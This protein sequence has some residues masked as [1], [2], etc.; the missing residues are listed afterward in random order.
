MNGVLRRFVLAAALAGLAPGAG[1]QA[2]AAAS[3]QD[4]ADRHLYVGQYDLAT[5]AWGRRGAGAQWRIDLATQAGPGMDGA[6]YTWSGFA[7]DFSSVKAYASVRYGASNAR[8]DPAV[9]RLPYRFGAN[10]T[11]VD[12]VWDFT[13]DGVVGKFN[14]TLDIFFN[15]AGRS[16]QG[17]IR[18]EIMIVTASSQDARTAGWG[19]RDALP[20]VIGPETWYVWQATQVSNGHSWHVTQFRKRVG[21]Q[22]FHHNLKDFFAAAAARRP[23]IFS[24]DRDVMMV[25]AGTEIKTG[26]GQ[27]RLDRYRVTV[28]PAP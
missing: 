26:A 4:G 22:A 10:G 23:D 11:D 15:A 19:V 12:V 28:T 3:A 16:G 7:G 8:N 24:A 9:T 20:F 5:N 27:V 14:H 18:G 21:S 6:R 13:A 25:E 17:A 2:A 1:A